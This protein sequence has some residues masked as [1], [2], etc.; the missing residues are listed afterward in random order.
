MIIIMP[1]LRAFL[2]TDSLT[3]IDH[4]VITVNPGFVSCYDPWEEILVIFTLPIVPSRQTRR[5]FCSLVSS[6]GTYFTEICMFKSSI[7]I[8]CMFL[9]RELACQQ[10][11]KW[12][13]VSLRWRFCIL[14]LRFCSCGLWRYDLNVYNLQP[15]FPEVWT[16]KHL[17]SSWCPLGIV[18]ESYFEHFMYLQY[19][20]PKFEAKLTQIHCFFKPPI[21][22]SL[23]LNTHNKHPLRSNAGVMEAK[24]PRLTQNI[25]VLR[26][27]VAESCTTCRSWSLLR[28]W[29]ILNMPSYYG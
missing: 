5:C 12:Y 6:R 10:S 19:D 18:T 29:E 8:P 1:V 24:L 14:S 16:R 7:R 11:S 28:V 3:F 21:R 25:V 15:K 17:K 2:M 13:S 22:K 27:L 26:R 4:W 9:T 23:S 20:V